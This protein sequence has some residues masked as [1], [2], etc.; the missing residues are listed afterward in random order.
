M[1]YYVL[2][3]VYYICFSLCVAG[4]WQRALRGWSFCNEQPAKPKL[5]IF[6]ADWCGPCQAAKKAMK[7]NVDSKKNSR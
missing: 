6:S 4:I 3:S 5:I 2:R 1:K 7:E